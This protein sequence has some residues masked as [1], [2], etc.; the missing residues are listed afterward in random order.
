VPLLLPVHIAAGGLAIIF[1]AA[2]LAAPK[3]RW[4]HRKSGLF[5]VYA[6]LTM[7]IS[8][9]VLAL[10]SWPNANVLGGFMCVYFVVTALTAVR[11]VTTWCTR[12][13]VAAAVVAM[14]LAAIEISTG[15]SALRRP[16]A[17]INGVPAAMLFFL[18]TVLLVSFAGDVRVIRS[19]PLRGAPRLARHLWRMCFALFIAAGSFFSIRARVAKILPPPFTTP[20]MRML[21]I[22]LVF[23]AMF[24]WLWRIRSPRVLRFATRS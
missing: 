12:I 18:A 11:P 10:T 19:G 17:S 9:S 15:M 13:N 24:F 20:A 3:G 16:H 6:M 23:A 1:G 22:V 5:F 7:G 4:L 21:P 14:A 8:G 2:A